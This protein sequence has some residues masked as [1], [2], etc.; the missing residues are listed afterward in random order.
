MDSEQRILD[1][2]AI[3]LSYEA[4]GM[5]SPLGVRAHSRR[6]AA[7]SKALVRG[8]PLQD[9]CATSGLSTTH[10]LIWLN[11][12][13]MDLAQDV[14]SFRVDPSPVCTQQS[15][16]LIHSLLGRLCYPGHGNIGIKIPIAST[17]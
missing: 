16:V 7:S 15:S 14:E 12:L 5:A 10:T 13:D 8:A 6:R 1:Y 9:V 11:R 2:N 4:R 3:T 17:A